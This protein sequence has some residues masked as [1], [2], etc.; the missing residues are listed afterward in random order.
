M[1]N[2]GSPGRG[3]SGRD[4]GDA[5]TGRRHRARSSRVECRFRPDLLSLEDRWLPSTFTVT[6]VADDSSAGSLRWAVLGADSAGGSNTVAFDPAHFSTPQS[7]VLTNGELVLTNGNITIDG[8]GAGLLTVDG[9]RFDRVFQVDK[10][11]TATISGLTIA[12]GSSTSGGG[13]YDQGNTTLIGCS[14]I[15][16]SATNGGGLYCGRPDGVASLT[17]TDCTVGG[18]SA[19]YG[20]AL[21]NGGTATL[22]GCSLI[23]D[24]AYMGGGVLNVKYSHANLADC[25]ISGNSASLGG[26]LSNYGRANLTACTVSGNN[27]INT[28]ANRADNAGGGIYNYSNH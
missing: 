9:N 28:T 19:N 1:R 13:L 4:R 12:G 22:Y 11:V 26:G 23:G 15:G 8:P 7:I 10:G 5:E 24:S 21:W 20:G 6:R 18:N 25:T 17:L 16:N 3:R 2:A 27:A 14:I